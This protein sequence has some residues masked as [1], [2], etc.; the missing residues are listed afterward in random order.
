MT[1]KEL[2]T[3]AKRLL[4]IP[5]IADRPQE[6]RKALNFVK[7]YI[8]AV[9]DVTIEQFEREGKPSLLAYIGGQRPAQF[10]VI[11][12]GHV[13]VVA[14]R[15]GQFKPY[16]QHGKLYGR[17]AL[18][19]KVTALVLTGIFCRLA[20]QVPYPLGLQLVTDEEVGGTNG[21]RYQIEQGVDAQFVIAG[22]FSKPGTVC[23]QSRG[24]CWLEVDLSGTAS[25]SA[26]LWNGDNAILQAQRFIA[27]L[28][29]RYPVPKADVW[30][31][32]VNVAS[33]ST[34]NDTFNRVPDNAKI[35]LDIRFIA[36]DPV[37]ASEKSL[38][39][40][41][42]I[43]NP[44][45]TV[46]IRQF[47]PSHYADP[48]D[49]SLRQLSDAMQQVTGKPATLIRKHGAADVR[50]Y[51]ARGTTAV[52]Y[53]LAGE[54]LHSDTEYVDVASIATYRAVLEH[55]LQQLPAARS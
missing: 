1:D 37:F 24:I 43:L 41:M 45:A 4:A 32:T 31:T 54:G 51:T 52:V 47:E 40:F 2:L 29:E 19:M 16:E 46:T 49:P 36:D 23:N 17:G 8:Q 42:Q 14:A 6:L 26:Y 50:H 53:G 21:T 25:H 20:P 48:D 3:A 15:P 11:L 35:L 39:A 44:D 33:V 5:S 38:R 27:K 7:R 30:A 28:L 13:D 12:N 55:F 22:E 10:T 9:P 18:D 34:G